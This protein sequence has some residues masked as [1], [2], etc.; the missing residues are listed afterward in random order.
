MI[1]TLSLIGPDLLQVVGLLLQLAGVL[2]MANGYTNFVHPG[3]LVALLSSALWRGKS[4]RGA[5]ALQKLSQ[6]KKLASLQGLAFVGLGFLVQALGTGWAMVL[7][8]LAAS[9]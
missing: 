6:E 3:D 5:A 1:Q 9:S 7:T 8:F 2:L 4:A